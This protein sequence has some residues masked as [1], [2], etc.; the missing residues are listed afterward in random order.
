[1]NPA[2]SSIRCELAG[3]YVRLNRLDEARW[4]LETAIRVAPWDFSAHCNLGIV[5]SALGQKAEARRCFQRSQW[6]NPA[7][8]EAQ[9]QLLLLDQSMPPPKS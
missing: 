7:F 9:R 3:V 2:D 8:A 4:Q 1:L 5:L 6:I